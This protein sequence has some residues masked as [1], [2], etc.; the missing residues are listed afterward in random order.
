MANTKSRR[1]IRSRRSISKKNKSRKN[2]SQLG[3]HPCD[4]VKDKW[5]DSRVNDWRCAVDRDYRSP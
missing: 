4:G 3:G 5:W 1:N 2:V